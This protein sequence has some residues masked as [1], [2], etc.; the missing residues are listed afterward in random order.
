MWRGVILLATGR[1]RLGGYRSNAEWPDATPEVLGELEDVVGK[2]DTEQPQPA[3]SMETAQTP[4]NAAP[5]EQGTFQRRQKLC[6]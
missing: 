4:D 3:R 1:Q 6:R 5:E 2:A